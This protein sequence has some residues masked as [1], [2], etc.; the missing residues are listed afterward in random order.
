MFSIY[1][2]FLLEIK[3]CVSIVCSYEASAQ[4]VEN[5]VLKMHRHVTSDDV[6]TYSSTM[7]RDEVKLDKEDD[8]EY[9]QGVLTRSS[10]TVSLK[11]MP[12]V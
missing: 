7:P 3:M 10:G 8:I 11:L 2:W 6:E 12:K 1:T 9:R 5:G 4:D